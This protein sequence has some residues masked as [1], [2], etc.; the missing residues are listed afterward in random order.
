MK[1]GWRRGLIIVGLLLLAGGG[2]LAWRFRP[3]THTY[4]SDGD[5]IRRIATGA[6]TREVLWQPPIR[7][8]QQINLPSDVYEPCI[9]RDGLTLYFVRGKAGKNADLFSCR[10]TYEGWTTPEPLAGVNSDNDELGPHASPDDRVLYFYSDRAGGLGGFDLWMT[11][12][13]GG[14][15]TPPENLGPNVNSEFNEYGAAVTPDGRSL[16]FASNRPRPDE[17]RPSHAGRWPA[18]LR[19]DLI[20]H[21]Y[22]LYR[23]AIENDSFAAA[24]PVSALNTLANEGSPCISPFGDF[25]YFSSDRDGGMGGFDL[26]RARLGSSC[27][28]VATDLGSDVNTAANELDPALSIGGYGLYFSSDRAGSSGETP[29]EYQLFYTASREVFRDSVVVRPVI[30]WSMLWRQLAP[31]LMWALL[32]LIALLLL[33]WGMRDF[34]RREL[35]LLT[36]CLL[37]S[38]FLHLMLMLLFNAWRVGTTLAREIGRGGPIQVAITGTATDE[39][40]GQIRGALTQIDALTPDMPPVEAARPEIALPAMPS[41]TETGAPRTAIDVA[42]LVNRQLP[43]SDAPTAP[44]RA[45]PAAPSIEV[46]SVIEKLEVQT[47]DVATPVAHSEASRPAPSIE[48]SIASRIEDM[49]FPTTQAE[50]RVSLAPEQGLSASASSSIARP[51]TPVEVLPRWQTSTPIAAAVSHT[52]LSSLP[53]LALPQAATPSVS[54]ETQAPVGVAAASGGAS[55]A[56]VTQPLAPSR[57]AQLDGPRAQV[58]EAAGASFAKPDASDAPVLRTRSARSASRGAPD[59]AGVGIAALPDLALPREAARSSTKSAEETGQIVAPVGGAPHARADL[60]I[61]RSRPVVLDGPRAEIVG[62]AGA[63]LIRPG[64]SDAPAAIVKSSTSIERGVPE[65]FGTDPLGLAIRI[66][67]EEKPPE[68]PYVQRAPEQRQDL[69]KQMGGSDRTE[70]AVNRALI[71]LAAHQGKGG[72]WSST[73]FDANCG[74]CSGSA[75]LQAD[76]AM[77]G[78]AVLCFLGADHTHM[79]DGPYRENVRRGLRWLKRRQQADGDLRRDESMYSQGIATIALAEAYGMTRDDSL[80]EPVRR[81]SEFIW[82]ARNRRGAGWRY[83]PGQFGDTSVL[84]WQIMALRSAQRAGVD[85][86]EEAFETAQRW[87]D[88]VSSRSRPGLYAYQ[89]GRAVTA[90]MTAEGMFVLQLTG[91]PT[92][93]ARMD[94]AAALLMRN[95]PDWDGGANTYYWYYATLALFQRQGVDWP[96]W[97]RRLTRELLAHQETVGAAAGSWS[98]EGEWAPAAGRVYQTALCTLMLEVYYR[99]LPMYAGG[100]AT[101]QSAASDR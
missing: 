15:W 65:P 71:W 59:P 25:L 75:Q 62:P 56:R 12:R 44:P 68:N 49:P 84:G 90:S 22:D 45:K 30:D 24:A 13:E 47:P 5:T 74:E 50:T 91:V 38:L 89:P 17:S 86:P 53:E 100:V 94:R 77:T 26:Y 28:E 52:G 81:A 66:P 87:L 1:R 2:A 80:A 33:L 83:E 41:M 4:L 78:L 95:R 3:R 70:S 19:E 7:L 42:T 51:S 34:K 99:Y 16:F 98:P 93:D 10:R 63:S 35:G 79:K 82:E 101:T 18:T 23:A 20:H 39:L 61:A 6:G 9:S 60:P 57:V 36:R 32:A 58:T 76:V 97:N 96:K 14:G 64:A 54:A 88:M 21:D 69:V 48:L 67:T 8:D 85:V 11:R 43:V 31:N 27:I 46:P 72:Q 55:H 40:A 37:L 92:T 73:D 29:A